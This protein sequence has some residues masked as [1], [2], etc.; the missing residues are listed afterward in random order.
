MT[1]ELLH[2]AGLFFV[3]FFIQ[4]PVHAQQPTVDSV[5]FRLFNKSNVI[6]VYPGFYTT[7]FD[8]TTPG[9]REPDYR[10]MANSSAY[11]GTYFNYKWLSLKY[12]FAMPGTQIDRAVKL[13][14][15]SLELRFGGRRIRFHPFYDSYNGLLIV[16]KGRRRNFVPFRNIQFTDAGTDFFYLTN[17][18]RFSFSAANYFSQQQLKSAGSFFLMVTPEWQKV[19]WKSPSHSLISDN[20]TY[21]LL[22]QNPQWISMIARIGYTYNFVFKSGKWSI[23]PAVLIGSGGVREINTTNR[24]IQSATD[25]QGWVNAGYNG[26]DYYFYISAWRDNLQTNLLIKNL[27]QVNTDFS[28]TAGFRF[29]SLKNK[30]FNML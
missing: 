14:Y 8:F 2:I 5:Y 9:K 10:L 7:R 4:L 6:E 21:N 15:T 19:K 1:N 13:Q 22:S 23:N 27:H 30:I 11:I 18:K 17:T 25:I 12:S 28:V 20:A 3:S 24:K 26:V 29:H 16:E